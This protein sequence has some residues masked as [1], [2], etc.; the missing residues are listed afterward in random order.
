MA[1]GKWLTTDINGELKIENLKMH[2]GRVH[3]ES[4][5]IFFAVE[6]WE[7]GEHERAY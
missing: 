7:E 6:K 4:L 2:V 5:C 1:N 3:E